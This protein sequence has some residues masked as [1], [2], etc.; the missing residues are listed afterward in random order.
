MVKQLSRVIESFILPE[1]KFISEFN[2][3]CDSQ[4]DFRVTL[5]VEWDE[6]IDFE[7]HKCLRYEIRSLFEML[8]PDRRTFCYIEFHTEKPQMIV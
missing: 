8:G 2:V 3:D 5:Y 7:T 6:Y 4:G 1:Y